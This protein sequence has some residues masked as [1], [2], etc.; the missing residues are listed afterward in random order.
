[1]TSLTLIYNKFTIYNTTICHWAINRIC[2]RTLLNKVD[3]EHIRVGLI[4]N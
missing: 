3:I 1:M 4:I 2:A